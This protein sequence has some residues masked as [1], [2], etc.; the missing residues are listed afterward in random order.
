MVKA[1]FDHEGNNGL[2]RVITHFDCVIEIPCNKTDAET[3]RLGGTGAN[4]VA[5]YE[6]VILDFASGRFRAFYTPDRTFEAVGQLSDEKWTEADK[7]CYVT[8]YYELDMEGK[9]HSWFL[10]KKPI[11]DAN[12]LF[13]NL[14]AVDGGGN[15]VKRYRVSPF[16][17]DYRVME[18]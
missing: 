13:I 2:L 18:F 1:T 9:Q 17:G 4:A 3:F 6:G 12:H 5:A 10:S 8:E 16:T 7:H 11:K 14:D 15:I